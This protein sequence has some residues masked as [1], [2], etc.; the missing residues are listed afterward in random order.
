MV[1]PAIYYCR[2]DLVKSF[3]FVLCRCALRSRVQIP[4]APFFFLLGPRANSRC[5]ALILS[6]SSSL[7]APALLF[8]LPLGSRVSLQESREHFAA[9]YTRR[10]GNQMKAKAGPRCSG[11][12]D[13]HIQVH[14]LYIFG[15]FFT[16]V[17]PENP[18]RCSSVDPQVFHFIPRVAILPHHLPTFARPVTPCKCL[19]VTVKVST[20]QRSSAMIELTS[21][22]SS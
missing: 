4:V 9:I 22:P 21:P 7:P 19:C 3:C 17:C 5:R 14:N 6:S 20:D 18:E 10:R 12:C 1:I 2:L 16:L 15:L 8:L 13:L 11:D